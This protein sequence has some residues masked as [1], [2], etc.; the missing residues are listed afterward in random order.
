MITVAD[1]PVLSMRLTLPIVGAWVLTAE[2]DGDQEPSGAIEVVQGDVR[3]AG[4]VVRAASIAGSVRL[5]AVGGAGGFRAELEA[6]SY[7]G[8]AVRDVVSD[9]L[10]AAGERLDP[11]GTR[12]VLD[13]T[14]PYWTRAGGPGG[15]AGAS[16]TRLTE[17]LGARWRVLPSGAVWV[18]RETWP[19]APEGYEALALDRDGSSDHVLLAPE[20]IGLLPGVILRGDRVGRVEHTVDRDAPLRTTFWLDDP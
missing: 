20:T 2:L 10:S 19:A 5:S 11:S 16:L 14:L 13:A 3:L 17:H 9:L 8:A 7:Q 4:T 6:R 18:G 1:L 12:E 15:R